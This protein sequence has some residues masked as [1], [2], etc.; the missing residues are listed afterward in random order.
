MT[1]DLSEVQRVATALSPWAHLASVRGDGS[2]DV[3]PVH[4]CWEGDTIWIM[5]GRD[6]V[7]TRNV[8]GNDRVALHW[9]VT[10][11]G[12]GVEVWGRATIHDDLPTKRRLWNGVF[13]YDLNA[14]APGGPDG[15]PDTVF[16]K[17]QVTRAM[18]MKAYGMAGIDRWQAKGSST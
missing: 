7:K 15:S 8:S 6:S 4:P 1:I 13:D 3:V 12:D 18:V 9:Q 11:S 14:F 5:V 16:M 10:E 17:V 2:P